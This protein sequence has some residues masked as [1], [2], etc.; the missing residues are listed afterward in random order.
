MYIAAIENNSF[1]S[2][3]KTLANHFKIL[4]FP[5]GTGYERGRGGGRGY[6]RGQ[7]RMGGRMGGRAGR[8]ENQE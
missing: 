7:G 6:G 2:N 8:G 5:E 1:W 4:A 3:F